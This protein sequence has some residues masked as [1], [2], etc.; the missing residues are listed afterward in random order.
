MSEGR[1]SAPGKGTGLA[2]ETSSMPGSSDAP[3]TSS[4]ARSTAAETAGA[5]A[6]SSNSAAIVRS[7]AGP[8]LRHSSTAWSRLPACSTL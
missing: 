2:R 8:R 5:V 1:A 3:G 4:S 6:V 7:P